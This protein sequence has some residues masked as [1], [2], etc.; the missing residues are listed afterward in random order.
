MIGTKKVGIILI[1]A[2]FLITTR[3]TS[4][5][6]SSSLSQDFW[7]ISLDAYEE[8]PDVQPDQADEGYLDYLRR[9]VNE[10]EAPKGVIST[11][12]PKRSGIVSYNYAYVTITHIR[13]KNGNRFPLIGD[14]DGYVSD[15]EPVAYSFHFDP[16]VNIQ[17]HYLAFAVGLTDYFTSAVNFQFTKIDS[18]T[19]I[20]YLGG[21]FS[22]P[23]LFW[24]SAEFLYDRME[25][26]DYHTDGV[27]FGDISLIGKYRYYSSDLIGGAGYLEVR[28]P[29]SE[30]LDPNYSPE[31][32]TG[33]GIP[34]GGRFESGRWAISLENDLD[35]F[36]PE[37]LNNFIFFTSQKYSI[38]IGGKLDSPTTTALL[39]EPAEEDWRDL[40]PTYEKKAGDAIFFDAGLSADILPFITTQVKYSFMCFLRSE[41]K[42]N[43]ASFDEFMNEQ[44]KTASVHHLEPQILFNLL[45]FKIPI[46]ISYSYSW[47]FFVRDFYEFP[48]HRITTNLYYIF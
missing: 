25:I 12:L 18:L 14:K 6:D 37:P 27:E 36:L 30:P 35:I 22:D 26:V 48:Y 32:A 17:Y 1:L 46:T 24:E 7:N 28:L 43:L 15:D 39:L 21:D 45:H 44:A 31:L 38:Q 5:Q 2:F 4:A 16:K 42:S 9:R 47:P 3:A 41:Y 11:T 10:I 20:E 19:N 13:D 40:G 8:E 29:T 33:I 23:E 34:N